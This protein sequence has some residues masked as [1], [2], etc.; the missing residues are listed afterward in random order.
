MQINANDIMLIMIM[1]M[2]IM[3]MIMMMMMMMMMMLAR[4]LPEIMSI[5][6][7]VI[8]LLVVVLL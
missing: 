3:M 1:M 8:L 4:A 6:L 5:P 7:N 2:M